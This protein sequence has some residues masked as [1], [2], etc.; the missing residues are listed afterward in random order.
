MSRSFGSTSFTS[1]PPMKMLPAVRSTRPA[2]RFRVVVFPQPDGPTRATNSPSATVRDTWSTAWNEPYVFTT[3]S[4]RTCATLDSL[5]FH[6]A[7][8][9]RA[10]KIALQ[11]QEHHH[12]RNA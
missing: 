7:F 6:C 4:N 10:H 3:A 8:G 2:I 5:R 1:R 11:D 9:E 12:Y